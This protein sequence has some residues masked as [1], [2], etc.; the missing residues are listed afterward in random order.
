MGLDIY[1]GSFT[2]YYAHQWET[3][4]QKAAREQGVP[5]VTVLRQPESPDAI[6]DPAVINTGVLQWRDVMLQGLRATGSHVTE[7]AWDERVETPYFTDKPGWDCFGALLILASHEQAVVPIFSSR[8]PKRL[9]DNWPKDFRLQGA[10]AAGGRYSHLLGCEVW[11]PVDF[12]D[13]FEGPK[14]NAQAS[15]FGS[16]IRLQQQL[17]ELNERTYHG[18]ASDLTAWRETVPEPADRTFDPMAKTGLAITIALVESANK[19]RLPMV[20]DY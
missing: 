12:P 13:P 11:L 9:P 8:Y 7:L 19:N 3:V 15:R 10:T 20:L 5:V 17:V 1:V 2:R 6:K 4:I 18:S 16:S 14:P